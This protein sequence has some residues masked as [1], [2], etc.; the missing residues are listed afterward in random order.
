MNKNT[1]RSKIFREKKRKELGDEKFKA[2][3]AT[4]KREYR[5]KKKALKLEQLSLN[6]KKTMK[7]L[8]EMFQNTVLETFTK[9]RA[10]ITIQEIKP[11]VQQK[12]IAVNNATNCDDLVS[13]ISVASKGRA[14]KKSIQ[15]SMDNIGLLYRRMNNNKPFDCTMESMKFL[16]DTKTVLD[17]IA[18]HD[19]WK[20]QNSKATIINA[21]TSILRRLPEHKASY[22]IYRLVNTAKRVE[23]DLIR[24]KNKLTDKQQNLILP[25]SGIQSKLI[26]IDD[27]TMDKA[28]YALFTLIPPRRSGNFASLRLD[29]KDGRFQNYLLVDNKN[30]PLTLV[31]NQYKTAKTYGEYRVDLPV[32]LQEILQT[33]F[34]VANLEPGHLVFPSKKGTEYTPGYFSQVVSKVFLRYTGK[35]LGST[36][37]RISFASSVFEKQHS[38]EELK[39]IA[40]GLG[41]SI[42]QM[43]LYQKI[44][45]SNKKVDF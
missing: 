19:K 21:I 32:K 15:Q 13:A 3:E 14:T 20:S 10:N 8:T 37:L 11:Q 41:H 31:L 23:L 5:A 12:L 36:A 1:E 26:T 39:K 2:Q 33:Y 40:L 29:R 17:F 42:S 43:S 24:D 6:E 18:G 22:D 4:R 35:K 45:L 9:T 7:E 44:D 38:V 28:I 30:R 34:T 27:G 16:D 25:W